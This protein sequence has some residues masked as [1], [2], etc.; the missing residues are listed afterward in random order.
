MTALKI[1]VLS[2]AINCLLF[3]RIYGLLIRITGESHPLVMLVLTKRGGWIAFLDDDDYLLDDGYAKALLP[4]LEDKKYDVIRYSSSYDT[5]PKFPIDE[6]IESEGYTWDLIKEGKAFLPSFVWLQAYRRSFIIENNIRFQNVA[7]FDDFLFASTV[8]LHNPYMLTVKA[9][10]LRYVV[11]SDSGTSNR[12]ITYSRAVA[13]DAAETYKLLL[14]VGH[15]TQADK[16]KKLWNLCLASMN[17]G[18]RIGVTRML[19]SK[20][21]YKEYKKERTFYFQTG[22]YPV[23]RTNDSIMGRFSV[24]IMNSI[25]HNW[26]AYSFFA[27]IFNRIIDPYVLPKIRKKIR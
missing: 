21:S 14:E 15:V 6:R 18:K 5:A 19:S 23:M 1:V 8:F 24:A 22:F 4:Y 13:H 20:Y 11:R 10:I 7:M 17:N 2:Y 9:N 16:D 12:S 25:M 3:T 27:F 26:I